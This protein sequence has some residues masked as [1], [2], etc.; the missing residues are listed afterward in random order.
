MISDSSVDLEGKEAFQI[1]FLKVM[2]ETIKRKRRR[3]RHHVPFLTSSPLGHWVA[4]LRSSDSIS[5]CVPTLSHEASPACR[6][7]QHREK[8]IENIKKKTD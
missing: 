3:R 7:P 5:I 6:D 4:M 2:S 8:E 1:L